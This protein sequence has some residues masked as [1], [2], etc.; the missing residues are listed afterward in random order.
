MRTVLYR[1]VRLP[2]KNNK[3]HS[4]NT[5]TYCTHCIHNYKHII[6]IYID[7]YTYTACTMQKREA[8][9]TSTRKCQSKSNKKRSPKRFL[10]VIYIGN[11]I[12]RCQS[13]ARIVC[14]RLETGPWP[15]K[16]CTTHSA[17]CTHSGVRTVI[18][19]LAR[20]SSSSSTRRVTCL[21]RSSAPLS[22]FP[23]SATGEA[24]AEKVAAAPQHH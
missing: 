20:S 13:S 4:T 6:Y 11:E 18:C 5:H 1:A 21:L 16:R 22:S 17:H 10:F 7:T 8:T 12:A 15:Q 9:T 19:V 3:N 14:G 23:Y 24:L 2:T